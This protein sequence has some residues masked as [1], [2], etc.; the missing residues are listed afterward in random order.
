M[1]SDIINLFPSS[2]HL[3]DIENYDLVKEE[4]LS[5][6][7]QEQENNPSS[8]YKS[9]KGGWQSDSYYHQ[10]DNIIKKIVDK[11]LSKHSEFYLDYKKFEYSALWFNINKKGDYNISH[12]H[13][14][15]ELSG[16]LWIKTPPNCGVIEFE[17]SCNYFA[18]NYLHSLNEEYKYDTKNYPLYTFNPT[19]GRMLIFP[20]YLRHQVE[21]NESDEERISVSFNL[22]IENR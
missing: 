11:G 2:V 16:V 5:F 12:H 3:I 7:Y 13:P 14:D 20:S 19:E 4:S 6:I 17:S 18:F 15:C 21:P 10:W 8:V 9:N 22:T 1:K